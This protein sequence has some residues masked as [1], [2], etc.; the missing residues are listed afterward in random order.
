MTSQNQG[1]LELEGPGA[2]P[3]PRVAWNLGEP[4][5]PAPRREGGVEAPRRRLGRSLLKGFFLLPKHTLLT[6]RLFPQAASPPPCQLPL[7]PRAWVLTP[8][9]GRSAP[10]RPPRRGACFPHARGTWQPWRRN[11]VIRVKT[12]DPPSLQVREGCP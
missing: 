2:G 3:A 8:L 4:G 5:A 12:P 6:F 7:R 9:P 10:A 1:T 11:Q